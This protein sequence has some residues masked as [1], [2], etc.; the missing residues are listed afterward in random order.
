[1]IDNPTFISIIIPIYN[2]ELYLV[3]CLGNIAFRFYK[4]LKVILI[5]DGSTDSSDNIARSF[6]KKD[7][8]LS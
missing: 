3:D 7:T 2:A 5:N 8:G 1:M 4:H 6:C